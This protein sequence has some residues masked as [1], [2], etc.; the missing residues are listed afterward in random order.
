MST[1][2]GVFSILPPGLRD[3]LREEYDDIVNRFHERK[4]S[5]SELSGGRFCEV[6][7]CIIE[8]YGSGAYPAQASKP[9][10]MAAACRAL[11]SRTNVPR[12][13]QILIPRLLPA[14]YEVRNNRGVGHVGGDVD[15]NQMD[16]TVVLSIAGW[17][18]AELVRVLH[19]TT[20]AE[21]QQIVDSLVQR[22]VP[23]IWDNETMRRV[24]N[25]KLKL[26]EQI[27]LLLSSRPTRVPASDLLL[28]TGYE[29]RAYFVR[30]LRNLHKQR[31]IELSIDE[32]MVDLLPPGVV[33]A[34]SLV[35]AHTPASDLTSVSRSR[36]KKKA[37]R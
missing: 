5:P 9:S 34:E 4:W 31:L 25:P 15:P 24:L 2:Q 11:E 12:S 19:S 23:L 20:T 21:A 16:A 6:V 7:Y 37:R 10:N 29:D 13:F 8:G 32:T 36:A 30:L 33:Q 27:L 14:L 35:R 3:Q 18:M 22:R 26:Q 28:W 1:R 17:I